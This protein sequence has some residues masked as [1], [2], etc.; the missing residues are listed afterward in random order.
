M[1]YGIVISWDG[2]FEG[3]FKIFYSC[4]VL[5][6]DCFWT[7][8]LKLIKLLF[9]T[10]ELVEDATIAILDCKILALLLFEFACI[11]VYLALQHLQ[12]SLCRINRR[13]RLV[14]GYWWLESCIHGNSL[15][16]IRNRSNSNLYY[17]PKE[18]SK[19]RL[20]D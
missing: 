8:F 20:F 17:Y 1:S 7:L 2:L 15:F 3:C 5:H 16:S 11:I 4:L 9:F 10:L 13:Q 12:L 19:W 18:Y 6:S 14:K